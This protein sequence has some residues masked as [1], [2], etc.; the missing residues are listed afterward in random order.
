MVNESCAHT[1]F[2]PSKK[3]G[4]AGGERHAKRN[5]VNTTLGITRL[6]A[7]PSSRDQRD[8][9]YSKKAVR[10]TRLFAYTSSRTYGL[11]TTPSGAHPTT[12]G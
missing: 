3:I 7:A 11:L 12:P 1:R 10:Q 9:A 4:G 6:F 2:T 8:L 5:V